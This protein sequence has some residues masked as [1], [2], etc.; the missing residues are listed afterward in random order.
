MTDPQNL[1]F[2]IDLRLFGAIAIAGAHSWKICQ[3]RPSLAYEIL[4]GYYFVI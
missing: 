3:S 1:E 2:L 4:N